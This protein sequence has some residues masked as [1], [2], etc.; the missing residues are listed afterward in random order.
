M[1]SKLDRDGLL[2]LA[3]VLPYSP[4]IDDPS[5]RLHVACSSSLPFS[6]FSLRKRLT[7]VCLEVKRGTR[8]EGALP[9]QGN[10]FDEQATSL[11]LDVLEPMGFK[12]EVR[13]RV[14][15]DGP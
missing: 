15:L 5:R 14:E 4:F 3:L 11:I 2:L 1:H 6:R 8:P 9:L 10:T 13:Q 12:V 7:T